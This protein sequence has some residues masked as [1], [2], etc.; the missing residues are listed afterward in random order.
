MTV[1]NS[2]SGR[3]TPGAS[4]PEGQR[5]LSE[6]IITPLYEDRTVNHSADRQA[7]VHIGI[8]GDGELI[9][10]Y[11]NGA[12]SAYEVLVSQ[13]G[14]ESWDQERLEG[15]IQAEGWRQGAS[16]KVWGDEPLFVRSDGEGTPSPLLCH[17]RR[18]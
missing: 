11:L 8:S 2:T 7:S 6:A 4:H 5:R 14:G 17:R 18:R 12:R 16:L 3:S 13:D 15:A 9:V 10:T 1:S